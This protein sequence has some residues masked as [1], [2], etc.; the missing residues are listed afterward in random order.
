VGVGGRI[1]I[2]WESVGARPGDH[3]RRRT[4]VF[5]A[6]LGFA[7]DSRASTV[8]RSP[9]VR[10]QPIRVVPGDIW[11]ALRVAHLIGWVDIGGIQDPTHCPLTF[12]GAAVVRSPIAMS[13]W[14]FQL[15]ESLGLITVPHPSTWLVPGPIVMVLGA[16]C[17]LA[18]TARPVRRR[19]ALGTGAFVAATTISFHHLYE[20]ALWTPTIVLLVARLACAY[21]GRAGLSGPSASLDSS[22]ADVASTDAVDPS[23]AHAGSA[24][25]N[26]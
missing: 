19:L 3:L 12:P 1:G 25:K 6:I 8:T 24:I 5:V 16:S 10:H 18:C 11:F 14:D 26:T 15:S 20:W 9:V 2:G 13:G 4:W 21:P 17:L 22:A 7:V 23:D